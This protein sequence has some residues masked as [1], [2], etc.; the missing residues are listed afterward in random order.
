MLK[1]RQTGRLVIKLAGMYMH[2]VLILLSLLVTISNT[3]MDITMKSVC[4]S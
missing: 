3:C 1:D 2:C 4:K